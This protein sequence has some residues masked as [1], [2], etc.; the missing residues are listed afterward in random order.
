MDQE[1]DEHTQMQ[2]D[3]VLDRRSLLK[4]AGGGFAGLVLVAC[5]GDTSAPSRTPTA[6]T[7]GAVSPTAAPQAGA[8]AAS[9]AAATAPATGA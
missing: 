7:T 4:L 9:T 3:L 8:T 5:G 1:H 2:Q 6:G